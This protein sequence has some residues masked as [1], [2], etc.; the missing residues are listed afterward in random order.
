MRFGKPGVLHGSLSYVLQ[1]SEGQTAD[2]HSCSAGL[3]YPGVGP[4]HAFWK[5]AGRA[6]Y[7]SVSDAE[8]MEA[9]LLM[10]RAE[11]IIPAAETA[12]AIAEAVRLASEMPS[13]QNLIVNVSGRGDKDVE[14]ALRLLGGEIE[15]MK[16]RA[17]RP[18]RKKKKKRVE[19]DA[20]PA[21]TGADDSGPSGPESGA[22]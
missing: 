21:E 5:D 11:G 2:V 7:T 9:F 18:K 10:A 14:E 17:S 3:D 16:A 1:D 12:H 20:P 6:T 15:P 13:E 8:A 4:E 19:G 22:G